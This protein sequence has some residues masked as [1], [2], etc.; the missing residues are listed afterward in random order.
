MLFS[1]KRRRERDAAEALYRSVSE[2]SRRPIL[3]T[4]LG[5]P[6][7]LEGR[8]E[9]L[10]LHLFPVVERL[11]SG[12]DADPDFSRL[13]AEAFIA[14][15]DATLREMGVG[16]LAV[17]RRVK[18]MY[19]AF[20]GRFAAYAGAKGDHDALAVA[21][22]RNVFDDAAAAPEAVRLASYLQA[23]VADLAS[24]PVTALK[25]GAPFFPDP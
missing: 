7:T 19:G 21:V 13:V 9:S 17:P 15:M 25:R 11:R 20:G 10:L 24:V 1:P 18:E 14:D 22:R 16:D 12:E 23:A 5:V 2:A 6:D 3:Y 4:D 8:F